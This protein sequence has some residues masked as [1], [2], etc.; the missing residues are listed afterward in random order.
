[1]ASFYRRFIDHFSEIVQPLTNLTKK[2]VRF[3]WTDCHQ[4]AFETLKQKLSSAPVLGHPDFNLPYKLYTDASLY[5]V[6]AVL[7]QEFPEGERVI[8]YLS[9]QLTPGQQKWPVIEREAYAIIFAVN[10][11]RHFLL[12]SKFTIF[13]DHKPLRSLFT[14]EMKNVRVQRWAIMLAEYGCDV[15]YKSGKTNVIADMLSRIP[16]PNVA[17]EIAVIDSGYCQTEEDDRCSEDGSE[18]F[19]EEPRSKTLAQTI[20]KSQ[21]EDQ[22]VNGIIHLLQQEN[23]ITEY[24]LQD[25]LLY[26]ISQPVKKDKHQRIQLVVPSS[27]QKGVLEEIHCSEFGGGH[28]GIDKTYDKLRSRYF[29]EGMYKDVANFVN[30]CKLCKAKRMR[31]ARVPMQDMPIPE[32]PFEIVGIDTCGPFPSSAKGNKYIVTVVD[33]FSSWPE[34]YAVP[35]KTAET[36]ASLLIEKFFPNMDVREFCYQTG[37]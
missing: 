17:D 34:A 5:A 1:M 25:G 6:G 12:G 21:E 27:M 18:C 3:Q 31:K 7:T 29:W 11:L 35:D 30:H 19:E 9:K 15:E 28:T 33:H 13:T 22:S 20:Q 36:I 2:N 24:V 37:Y 16:P 8:Q 23:E 14:S 32:F 26:H 10:K 4:N